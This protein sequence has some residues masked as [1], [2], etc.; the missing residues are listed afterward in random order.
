[1]RDEQRRRRA[2][3]AKPEGPGTPNPFHTTPGAAMDEMSTEPKT[4]MQIQHKITRAVFWLLLPLLLHAFPAHT[5]QEYE[6][7]WVLDVTGKVQVLKANEQSDKGLPIKRFSHLYGNT[8]LIL[9]RD[10]FVV[11]INRLTFQID[12]YSG[13]GK[14]DI[15]QHGVQADITPE[16]IV[17]P[18]GTASLQAITQR[19]QR[20]IRT[21]AAMIGVKG[22]KRRALKPEIQLLWPIDDELIV[23]EPALFQWKTKRELDALHLTIQDSKENMILEK[24]VTLGRF[25]L[26]SSIALQSGEQYRWKLS[27]LY[28]NSIVRSR[29]H[30]FRIASV[31]ERKKLRDVARQAERSQHAQILYAM[32]LERMGAHQAAREAWGRLS[33]KWP[34]DPLFKRKSMK[35]PA[36]LLRRYRGALMG[37]HFSGRFFTQKLRMPDHTVQGSYSR[38]LS[39]F[40]GG[41]RTPRCIQRCFVWPRHES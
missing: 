11:L 16:G 37:Q 23:N 32:A 38:W 25:E 39:A 2:F 28:K 9:S 27:G 20:P 33:K 14:I 15:T 34:D 10:S 31:Q 22:I 26:P 35:T 7:A 12:H 36:F 8:Q 4:S 29:P 17:Q 18:N 24:R 6:I 3:E 21:P 1:M 5:G 19:H 13:P 30:T 41:C 40:S